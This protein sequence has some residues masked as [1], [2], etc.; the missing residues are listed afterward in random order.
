MKKYSRLLLTS[1]IAIYSNCFASSDITFRVM[2]SYNI[3]SGKISGLPKDDKVEQKDNKSIEI[4]NFA[5]NGMGINGYVS[6]FL[7]E[8]I[9]AELGT[10]V[11]AFRLNKDSLMGVSKSYS[12]FPAETVKNHKRTVVSV[13]ISAMFQIYTPSLL[14]GFRGYGGAGYGVALLYP[15]KYIKMRPIHGPIIE[16]GADYTTTFGLSYHVKIRKQWTTSKVTYLAGQGSDYLNLPKDIVAKVK[17][18][19]LSFSAGIGYDF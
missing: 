3:I 14:T 12:N 1:F 15:P 6:V 16:L 11:T 2:P 17:L 5:S 10:G 4:K 18:D 19:S 7:G 13:P 8:Y 9:A